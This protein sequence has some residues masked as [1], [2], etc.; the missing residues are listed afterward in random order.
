M[1]IG[2]SARRRF[3]SYAE[4][5][6]TKLTVTSSPMV[7]LDER[8]YQALHVLDLVLAYPHYD[9]PFAEPCAV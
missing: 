8:D 6:L 7:D 9:V 1:G 2:L 5:V 3:V 4:P